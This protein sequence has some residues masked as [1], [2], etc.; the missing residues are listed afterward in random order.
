M[1]KNRDVRIAIGIGEKDFQAET[2]TASSGSAS[3]RS[4]DC[5]ERLKEKKRTLAVE[6]GDRLRDEELNT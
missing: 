1:V 2:V 3:I 4:G 6:T 5:F